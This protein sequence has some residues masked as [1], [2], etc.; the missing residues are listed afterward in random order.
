MNRPATATTLNRGSPST[1]GTPGSARAACSAH[2]VRQPGPIRLHTYPHAALHSLPPCPHSHIIPCTFS[3]L[4]S[5]RVSSSHVRAISAPPAWSP[6]A[7]RLLRHLQPV[8]IMPSPSKRTQRARRD[9]TRKELASDRPDDS[10]PSRPAKR[11][12]KVRPPARLP[13]APAWH[14]SGRALPCH[15]SPCCHA[16]LANRILTRLLVPQL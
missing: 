13:V 14:S 9:S 1:P 5:A 6:S 11:R 15:S 12:K 16:S 3:Y 7:P 10:S 8:V 4:L 2:L